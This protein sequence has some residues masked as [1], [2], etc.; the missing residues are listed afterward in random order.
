MAPL[1]G[2]VKQLAVHGLE[3][4]LLGG[5]L[6]G[7]GRRH[8][9]VVQGHV[10]HHERHPVSVLLAEVLNCRVEGDAGF[11][12]EIE[13]LHEDGVTALREPGTVLTHQHSGT[14]AVIGKCLLG[15][16]I[17]PGDQQR[18]HQDDQSSRDQP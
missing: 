8:R 9:V 10:A 4:A 5:G 6:G 12:F 13:E 17:V 7:Q 3:P 2:S 11:A 18:H 16:G 15:A 14:R 1:L